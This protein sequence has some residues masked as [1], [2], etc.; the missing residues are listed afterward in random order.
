MGHRGILL[1]FALGRESVLLMKLQVSHSMIHGT[2]HGMRATCGMMSGL[3]MNG[4]LGLFGTPLLG[5]MTHGTSA[6]GTSVLQ[7]RRVE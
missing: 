6:H 1:S 4:P 5:K 2:L 3:L 7:C